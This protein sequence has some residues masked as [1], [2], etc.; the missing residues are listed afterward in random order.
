MKKIVTIVL[1][2]VFCAA[3]ASAD[4]IDELL[5]GTANEQIR[6]T[7]RQMVQ[8]GIN[9]GDAIQ[10]LQAMLSNGFDRKTVE[11][12]QTILTNAVRQ[13]LPAEP[14]MNKAYE[15][16]AKKVQSGMIVQAMET[17]HSRYAF[18]YQQAEVFTK[19]MRQVHSLGDL[20]ADTQS[21]GMGQG[22]M[23]ILSSRLRERIDQKDKDR[24]YELAGET[25]RTARDMARLGTSPTSVVDVLSQALKHRYSA[26]EMETLRSSFVQNARQGVADT[27]A[28]DYA[29]EIGGGK[30][31]QGLG[32][33]ES[34]AS[35]GGGST[36]GSGGAGSGG[37]G[38]SNGGSGDSGSGSGDS[39][40]SGS[41]GDG[42]GGSGGSDGG[43]GDSGS[44]SGDSGSSGSSGDGSGG[45]DGS[46]GGSGDSGSGSGDSGSS[47]SSGDGSGGSGGSDGGS[48][49]SGSGSGDS[50]SSGS[51]GDSSGGSGGSDGG[52]G[53]GRQ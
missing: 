47:G 14:I 3:V 39:G 38:G 23:M 35:S 52:S 13:G 40:S 2:V 9:S 22:D 28:K 49:D 33:P 6:N 20:M 37:S 46:D 17:V 53:G 11:K 21:A 31:A 43:S 30:S 44:G 1:A 50:G 18:A 29:G 51:S 34:G 26:R 5:A 48:G 19:D 25:F 8:A 41:S 12:A 16:M 32:S 42:S 24:A 7:T 45:S 15:G 27:L 36:G 10:L 4:E